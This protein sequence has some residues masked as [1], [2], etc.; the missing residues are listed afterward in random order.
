[1]AAEEAP[2]LP[3]PQPN[4]P[5]PPTEPCRLHSVTTMGEGLRKESSAAI[6]REDFALPSPPTRS[7]KIIQRKPNEQQQQQQEEDQEQGVGKGQTETSTA[8]SKNA[9]VATTTTADGKKKAAPGT[10]AGGRKIARKT[11]HS[12]IERR[13]RSRINEEFGMLK[14][15]VPAC[16][17]QEMQKLTILQVNYTVLPCSEPKGELR[18]TLC[19]GNTTGQSANQTPRACTSSKPALYLT[20]QQ[21][22][23]LCLSQL[24][25]FQYVERGDNDDDD[26]AANGNE[27]DEMSDAEPP[28]PSSAPPS[29]QT[30]PPPPTMTRPSASAPTAPTH[31]P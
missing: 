3:A 4:R 17:G 10:I 24:S 5:I 30:P 9:V 7:K 21:P 12:L 28:P 25:R 15:M 1:M 16:A 26:G 20:Q 2:A 29:V 6:N 14:D 19:F 27:D 31:R 18:L 8:S 23:N 22:T 13:R 11:A